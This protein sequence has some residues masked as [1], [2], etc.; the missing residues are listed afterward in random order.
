MNYRIMNSCDT[1]IKVIVLDVI[2]D[3]NKKVVGVKKLLSYVFP[4]VEYYTSHESSI[5]GVMNDEDKVIV[6][7]EEKIRE[8]NKIIFE[9]CCIEE[10]ALVIYNT[11]ITSVSGVSSFID[12][13]TEVREYFIFYQLMCWDVYTCCVICKKVGCK[14]PTDENILELLY[15]FSKCKIKEL[16]E[17]CIESNRE[18]VRDR[19]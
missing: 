8:E 5:K 12:P 3:G 9:K 4:E 13:V 10:D 11:N 18:L 1:D 16:E 19:A 6:Y 15:K 14:R 2:S 7:N 17:F